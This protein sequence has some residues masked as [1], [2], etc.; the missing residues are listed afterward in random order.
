MVWRDHA[1]DHTV[2]GKVAAREFGADL[3]LNSCF[4]YDPDMPTE[5]ELIVVAAKKT[6]RS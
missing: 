3:W 5:F 6:A 1:G 4:E 2:S